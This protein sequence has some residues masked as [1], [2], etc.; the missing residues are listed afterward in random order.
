MLVERSLDRI[1]VARSPVS[2]RAAFAPWWQIDCFDRKQSCGSKKMSCR[3]SWCKAW[4][5][6]RSISLKIGLLKIKRFMTKR[7]TSPV[8]SL[9]TP[10]KRRES[11]S[12]VGLTSL[13]RRCRRVGEKAVV[14]SQF[15]KQLD[16]LFLTT[17]HRLDMKLARSQIDWSANISQYRVKR[18]E[19]AYGRWFRANRR[20]ALTNGRKQNEGNLQKCS[21]HSFD[22]S[23]MHAF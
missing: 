19:H 3:K 10:F 15:R 13:D 14:D 8:I 9:R 6:T 5:V 21:F 11:V 23:S 7:R 4:S 2:E 12:L 20:P 17:N 16:R 1:A 22:Q 18:F